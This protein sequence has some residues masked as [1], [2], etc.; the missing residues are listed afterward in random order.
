M[1]PTELAHVLRASAEIAQEK[2][3]VLVGGQVNFAEFVEILLK[4]RCVDIKV[5][6]QRINLLDT[7]KYRVLHIT[8]WTQRRALEAGV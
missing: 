3:F 5:L 6:L 8:Q 1:Q 4:Y 7:T 2:S